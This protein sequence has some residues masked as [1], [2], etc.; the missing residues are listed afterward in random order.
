[1]AIIGINFYFLGITGVVVAV[2]ALIVAYGTAS[3]QAFASKRTKKGNIWYGQVLGLKNFINRAEKDRLET[4]IDEDPQY[5]YKVLPYA[6]VLGVTEKW[7][8]Q[9][10]GLAIPQPQWYDGSSYDRDFY[11]TIFAAD[12]TD[13][14]NRVQGIGDGSEYGH[15]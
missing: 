5:F 7:I 3:L 15:K 6:F 9:F 12:F 2:A 4:L 11:P 14:L 1:M 10:T 13:S 8:D